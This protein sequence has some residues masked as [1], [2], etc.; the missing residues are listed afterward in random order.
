MIKFTD[1]HKEVLK[2]QEIKLRK[3]KKGNLI[4]DCHLGIPILATTN[5]LKYDVPSSTA[6]NLKFIGLNGEY[7]IT[8]T[9]GFGL[10]YTRAS[11]D[12]NFKSDSQI[13]YNGNLDKTRVLA[14]FIYYNQNE[15]KKVSTY[16]LF[17]AGCKFL[18]MTTNEP[19]KR[20]EK[21]WFGDIMM[22]LMG[23]RHPKTHNPLSILTFK[24][25]YG[26]RYF[27]NNHLG[28]NVEFGLGGPL[29]QAGIS[30]KI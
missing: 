15:L 4:I 13:V 12:F 6:S 3:P 23:V 2:D 16:Y 22:E 26:I 28:V 20:E 25:A 7:L 9:I 27:I 29:I 5:L 14:K 8:E 10:E 24:A 30:V 21:F 1:G 17:G 11:F 19:I 18:T